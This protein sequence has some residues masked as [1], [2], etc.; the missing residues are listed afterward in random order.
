MFSYMERCV[1][2][3][4]VI[5]GLRDKLTKLSPLDKLPKDKTPSIEGFRIRKLKKGVF[6]LYCLSLIETRE[7]G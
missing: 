1:S 5:F 3:E 2:Y 7:L 6:K 4:K